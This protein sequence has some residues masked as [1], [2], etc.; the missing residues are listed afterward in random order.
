MKK[1]IL[2]SLFIGI[3]FSSCQKENKNT[4]NSK[5]TLSGNISISGAFALYPMTIR[6]VEEFKKLH[7][8][9]EINI[10]AG[11]AGKGITDVLSN[12]VDLAMF[13]KEINEE[14]VRK[15]A[16]GFAV[17]IDAVIPTI[18]AKNP[19]LKEIKEKG[20]KKDEFCDIFITQEIKN[21][22]KILPNINGADKINVFTRSDACGAAE[23]WAKYLN[24]HKQENLRGIGLNGDPVI[25]DAIRKDKLSIGY[26]NLAYI[27]DIN[28]KNKYEGIEVVPIDINE[29]GKI[30][31]EENF[32]D[33]LENLM[34]A[35]ENNIYPSPPA[36]ELYFISNGKIK[37]KLVKEF[38]KWILTEGQ[39]YVSEAGYIKLKDEKI[40]EQLKKM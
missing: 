23:V 22:S 27:Y 8:N 39:K 7:P 1:I 20:L 12:M 19:Y 18:N 6:W 16:F 30:D 31:A 35:I 34:K 21:W 25:A 36:R 38:V 13:S 9:V 26:N 5:D 32:Y 29:N 33:N 40:K 14:E 24:N 3:L 11:G 2:C 37:N 4:A 28:T 17:C 15:G 10:S